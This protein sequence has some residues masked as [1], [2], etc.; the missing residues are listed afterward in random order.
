VVLYSS[1]LS[2]DSGHEA[3]DLEAIESL[4]K[5]VSFEKRPPQMAYPMNPR[6]E[7]RESKLR[8]DPQTTIDLQRKNCLFD[9]FQRRRRENYLAFQGL[10]RLIKRARW[11]LLEAASPC[12]EN[13]RHA[14]APALDGKQ[15]GDQWI[16]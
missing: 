12:H 5:A 6:G 10:E 9:K 15:R 3:L 13:D 8:Q 14:V 7:A 2:H 16:E 1:A 4:A 11:N